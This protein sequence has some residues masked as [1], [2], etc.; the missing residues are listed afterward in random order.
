MVSSYYSKLMKQSEEDD[1][2]SKYLSDR[3][4]S[5]VWLIKSIEQRK[6]TIYNVVDVYKRQVLCYNSLDKL[7][8]FQIVEEGSP[9]Y[10]RKYWSC[11]I[12]R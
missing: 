8:C 9:C 10:R 1:N 2:L 4:N 6:Q 12:H 7:K 11:S 5:A 3:V